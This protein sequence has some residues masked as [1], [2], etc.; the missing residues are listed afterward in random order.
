[1]NFQFFVLDAWHGKN[2]QSF[3]PFSCEIILNQL[4]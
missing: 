1:M 2:L 3:N 4:T